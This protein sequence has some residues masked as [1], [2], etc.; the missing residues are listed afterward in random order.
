M[1]HKKLGQHFLH[2]TDILRR[3]ADALLLQAGDNVIEIGPG[4][5]ALTRALVYKF[6]SLQV[7]TFRIIAIEKDEKLSKELGLRIKDPA[8][9]SSLSLRALADRQGFEII[10]GDAL[11]VLPEITSK[12]QSLQ[13]Y[14]LVGNIPFYI[15]G[16]LFRIIGELEHKPETT[17]LMI[18]KEV[19]ERVSAKPPHF[20]LLAA[21]VQ[22][23]ADVECLFLVSR[24]EFRPMPKVDSA[25]VRLRIKALGSESPRARRDEGL[26][27]N[28]EY[29][30]LIKILFK[31]PRKT[32]L[33]NLSEGL[34]RPK[35]EIVPLLRELGID[36]RARP[37][38]FGVELITKLL[39]IW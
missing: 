29:Y 10:E 5:G 28:D 6:A 12:L 30:K 39:Q 20:N 25:V 3:V 8:D 38:I 2:N 15:T 19:A 18:Q 31:Q 9:A 36:E 26:R 22:I 32:A 24:K 13:T 4:R 35:Q 33:N 11:R 21:S 14:K 7:D 23:W 17:V 27:I 16:K 1:T 34:R 37:Q